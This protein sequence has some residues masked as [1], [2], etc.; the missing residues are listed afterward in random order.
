LVV[1]AALVLAA[2]GSDDDDSGGTTATTVTSRST[3]SESSVP[4]KQDGAGST[5]S[6][7]AAS[8]RA[9]VPEC[10]ESHLTSDPVVAAEDHQRLVRDISVEVTVVAHRQDAIALELE[11][12]GRVIGAMRIAGGGIQ[13]IDIQVFDVVDASC[14]P[15]PFTPRQTADEVK[16]TR[17]TV[18][19]FDLEGRG[20]EVVFDQTGVGPTATTTFRRAS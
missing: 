8:G 16:D 10:F 4:T 12:D 13:Q 5:T 7:S 9:A 17:Q 18:V 1:P 2:C 6:T 3:T 19:P 11:D 14:A 15:V 20:Y